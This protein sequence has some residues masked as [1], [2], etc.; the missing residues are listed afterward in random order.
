M[1][2]PHCEKPVFKASAD[3]T[4]LKARTSMLVIHK[5]GGVE[6]NCGSCSRGVLIPMTLDDAPFVLKKAEAP[7]RFVVRR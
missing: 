7:Q 4:K 3:G 1:I 5:G 2:C 6:V